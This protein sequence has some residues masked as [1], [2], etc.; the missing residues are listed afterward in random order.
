MSGTTHSLWS[1]GGVYFFSSALFFSYINIRKTFQRAA[2]VISMAAKMFFAILLVFSLVAL[3]DPVRACIHDHHS[4]Q[5][6]CT[7][8]GNPSGAPEPSVRLDESTYR[9]VMKAVSGHQERLALSGHRRTVG[10]SLF[11][12]RFGFMNNDTTSAVLAA[13]EILGRTLNY[14]ETTTRIVVKCNEEPLS[15]LQLGLAMSTAGAGNVMCNVPTTD[16][17]E[18][19]SA[20]YFRLATNNTCDTVSTVDIIVQLSN[21]SGVRWNK[22][23]NMFPSDT[24]YDMVTVVMHELMHGLG[25]N[26]AVG[27]VST[28][29]LVLKNLQDSGACPSCFNKFDSHLYTSAFGYFFATMN[30]SALQSM[31]VGSSLYWMPTGASQPD[32]TMKIYS[33]SNF[34]SGSTGSHWDN[35]VVC[36][37]CLAQNANGL[38]RPILTPGTAIH[39]IGFNTETVLKDYG[40]A[41]RDCGAYQNC[42]SCLAASTCTWCYSDGKCGDGTGSYAC[43]NTTQWVIDTN[44]CATGNP[45]GSGNPP[46]SSAAILVAF[47]FD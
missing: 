17:R 12:F 38:M 10:V 37:G 44:N 22:D 47:L 9:S 46:T 32:A 24:E 23:V 41:V 39:A 42:S 7:L 8:V 18:R 13:A 4:S 1:F 26:T 25:F 27:S 28:T 14:N 16:V 21:A 19:V 35:T 34:Q 5:H 30:D 15:G 29:P 36:S 31:F 6:E 43:S 20:P 33:P 45:V 11:D 40:Y 3:S 2:L